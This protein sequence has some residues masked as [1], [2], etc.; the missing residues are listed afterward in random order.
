V[1]PN[2]VTASDTVPLTFKL[3]GVSGPQNLAISIQN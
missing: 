2:G 3:N 1:V